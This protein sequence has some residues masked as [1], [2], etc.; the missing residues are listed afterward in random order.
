M[1]SRTEIKALRSTC[2]RIIH[3]SDEFVAV[4]TRINYSSAYLLIREIVGNST[5]G[6]ISLTRNR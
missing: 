1:Q 4:V 6:E 2:S 3:A 5:D